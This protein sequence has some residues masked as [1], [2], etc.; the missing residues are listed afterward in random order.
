MKIVLKI[1]SIISAIS[2][3]VG[4]FISWLIIPIILVL[5][6]EVIVRYGFNSPTLWA[7]PLDSNLQGYYVFL[8]AAFA[9]LLKGFVSMDVVHSR[10]APRT[11]A[12][13]DLATAGFS[14][15]FCSVLFWGGITYAIKAVGIMETS[16]PPLYFPLYPLRVM[17]PIGV[18]LL[19][20]QVFAKFLGDI[21]TAITGR[22]QA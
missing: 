20:L 18:G 16:G 17:L 19:W 5:V 11:K 4:Q 1:I 6:Y 10:F 12:M 15:V 8:G 21:L 3:R 7:Y 9:F 14:F 13:V 22:Q 2:E